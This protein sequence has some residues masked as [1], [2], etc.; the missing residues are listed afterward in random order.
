MSQRIAIID[1]GS[2]SI[3]MTVSQKDGDKI[4]TV[5]KFR[6]TV[7]LGQGMSVS[8]EIS[9]DAI[10]RARA[11]LISLKEKAEKAGS[12]KILAVATAAVRQAKNKDKF[13]DMI[14]EVGIDFRILSEWDEAYYGFMGIRSAVEL[15]DYAIIDVGGGSSEISLV[16]GGKLLESRSLSFGAVILTE[17]AS[18][19]DMY[20][21]I[22][23]HIDKISFIDECKGL[24]IIG[25]GGTADA[26]CKMF[27]KDEISIDE[28]NTGYEKVKNTPVQNRGAID[29][30]PDDRGD[31]ILGGMTIIKAFADKIGAPTLR[32]CK[33]GIRDGI[34]REGCK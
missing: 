33:S 13:V 10:E 8:G 30:V 11:S 32:M 29:G 4:T 20:D 2:N 17:I 9:C 15:D 19:E 14:N 21:F 23:E 25:L 18:E 3:K 1:I 34:L 27:D 12:D 31:I 24:G 7:R 22:M 5:E 26:A 6:E 16:R 28:L